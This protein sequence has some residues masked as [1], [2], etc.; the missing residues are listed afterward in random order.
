[1]TLLQG[2]RRQKWGS[3]QQ[4]SLG[5][6]HEFP[7]NNALSISYVGSLGRHLARSREANQVPIGVGTMQAPELAG[8][9]G[10]D[11]AGNCDVQDVLINN[12]APN[13]HFLPY[14]GYTAV[15][16]KENTAISHYDSLQVNFRHV[17]GQGLTF[18]ASYTWSHAIDDSSSRTS[19]TWIDDTNLSRWRATRARSVLRPCGSSASCE[20]MKCKGG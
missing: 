2:G 15:L 13:I 16:M 19:W 11:A 5:I 1:V 7:G 3:V 9:E 14:R 6:Q 8:L 20:V 17:F 12:R 10:C 4:F 18:Q